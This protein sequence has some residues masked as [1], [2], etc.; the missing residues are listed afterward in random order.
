MAGC[1][2]SRFSSDEIDQRIEVAHQQFV[3]ADM[4]AHPSRFHRDNVP[5]IRN[6]EL[7]LY[8]RAKIDVVVCN[9]SADAPYSGGYTERDGTVVPRLPRYT[10]KTLEP[11]TAYAFATDRLSRVMRTIEDGDAIFA[12][13][14]QAVLTARRNRQVALI[15]ALEGADSLEGDI[16]N[17]YKLHQQGLR[18]LQ[19]V[20]FRVN[21]VGHIQ[22]YPYTPG[23][24]TPFGKEVVQTAN[25]LSI[26]IDLAHANSQTI[27]D[28]LAISQHPTIFSHTGAK[29]IEDRDRH[30]SDSE[31]QAIAAK[32]GVM[33]IWPN[34]SAVPL[35]RHLIR[36]IDHIKALV[37]IDH[38][39]I[40]SDLR[41]VRNY[42]FGFGHNA[43]FRAIAKALFNRGYTTEEVGKIMGGNF[44]R[45]WLTIAA[46]RPRAH[47]TPTASH[48]ML[49]DTLYPSQSFR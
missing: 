20:H 33:G 35:M 4:H 6:G 48:H 36:H 44:F 41:G 19:L 43:N 32:G 21:E 29:A 5:R 1:I 49:G 17:L 38:V 28:V 7:N 42:T 26:I 15:P 18:L 30:L 37:G 22:T 10:F 27:R 11:G 40:G 31:I 9:I 24:L 45:V 39:G 23:G 12:D 2:G 25:Q 47:V 16:D 34:G 14:P 13:H 3:F 8:K 46:N